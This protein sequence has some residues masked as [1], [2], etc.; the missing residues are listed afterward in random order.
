MA[1]VGASIVDERQDPAVILHGPGGVADEHGLAALA[2][3]QR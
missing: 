1:R 2:R 3:D